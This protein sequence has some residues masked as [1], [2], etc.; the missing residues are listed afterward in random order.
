MRACTIHKH[1][2]ASDSQDEDGKY[3]NTDVGEGGAIAIVKTRR[4]Q[5]SAIATRDE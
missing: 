1:A 5:A 3:K 4:K 2:R